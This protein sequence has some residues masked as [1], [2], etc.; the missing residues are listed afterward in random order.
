MTISIAKI[1]IL[2]E[3]S[4]ASNITAGIGGRMTKEAFPLM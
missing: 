1:C 2:Q 3:G 4:D